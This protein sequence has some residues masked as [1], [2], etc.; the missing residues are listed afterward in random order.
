MTTTASTA[1][2]AWPAY[3]PTAQAP[4]DLR[5]VVHLHRAAGVAATWKEIQRD[6]ADGPARS[7]DRLL[8]GKARAEGVPEEFDAFS[9][10]LAECASDPGRLRA[11]WLY[12]MLFGPDALGERL[13]LMWHNHFA[14]SMEKVRSRLA[15]LAQN[16]LFRKHGRGPFGELLKAVVADPALLLWLDAADNR[17]GRPNEN[18]ARELLELFTLGVGNYSETDVKETARALTGWGVA[19]GAFRDVAAQHDD[20]EKEVLGSKGRWK[21]PDVVRL[22]LAHRATPRRLAFRLTELLMGEGTSDAQRESLAGDLGRNGLDV[23]KAVATVLRSAAFHGE[24]SFGRRVV[25]P[26]EFVVS[27]ARALELFD[28]PPSTLLLADWAARLGQDLFFPPNVGGWKGGRDWLSPR[29]MIGRANFAAALVAGKLSHHA[30]P[31]DAIGLARRHARADSLEAVVV[32]YARLLLG[33]V[34]SASWQRRLL[35]DLGPGASL[36]GDSARR[37]VIL[38]LASPEAQ[39]A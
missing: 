30:R 31:L 32:F 16:E 18:L 12:R 15:M 23:G 28:A 37:V 20:G 6:L 3:V 24:A 2:P 25:G 38:V 33:A 13:V 10:T 19:E 21:T 34:P 39:L 27:A 1:T 26:V 29:T 22:L 14:T 8:Q 7:V 17:K 4:W 9:I 11:W 5:R 35:G 36:N